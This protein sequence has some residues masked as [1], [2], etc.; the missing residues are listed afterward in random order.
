M[1]S[2]EM[3]HEEHRHT[4]SL[5]TDLTSATLFPGSDPNLQIQM[6]VS[7]TIEPN[8]PMHV[9]IGKPVH[10]FQ[11]AELSVQGGRK[12]NSMNLVIVLAETDYQQDLVV[13]YHAFHMLMD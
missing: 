9:L 11:L 13:T 2:L 10:S 4:A 3:R 5:K 7:A 12:E 6:L 1:C 8:K